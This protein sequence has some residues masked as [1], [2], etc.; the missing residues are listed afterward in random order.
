MAVKSGLCINYQ[1]TVGGCLVITLPTDYQH[2]TDNFLI[3]D[4]CPIMT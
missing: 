4:L 1:S 2:I 3:L